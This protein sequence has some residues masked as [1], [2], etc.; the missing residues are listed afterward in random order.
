MKFC[1]KKYFRDFLRKN[2]FFVIFPDLGFVKG[3]SHFS[4]LL[5]ALCKGALLRG[6]FW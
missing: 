6:T 4:D 2:I 1:E 3:P 5:R